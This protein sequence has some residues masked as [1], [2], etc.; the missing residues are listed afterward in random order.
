MGENDERQSGARRHEM[1]RDQLARA[2]MQ[3]APEHLFALLESTGTDGSST[4]LGRAQRLDTQAATARWLVDGLY[5]R[6]VGPRVELWLVEMQSRAPRRRPERAFGVLSAAMRQLAEGGWP[7]NDG[8]RIFL[9]EVR[10]EQAATSRRRATETLESDEALMEACAPTP[11]LDFLPS[12][13]LLLEGYWTDVLLPDPSAWPLWAFGRHAGA[14]AILAAMTAVDPETRYGGWITTLLRWIGRVRFPRDERFREAPEK[15]GEHMSQALAELVED[16]R[17]TPTESEERVRQYLAGLEEQRERWRKEGRELGRKEGREQGR[18]E[19]HEQG[20]E[21]GKR[22]A[23]L[24]LV[25][26]VS[27]E[28]VASLREIRDLEMLQDAA[29]GIIVGLKGGE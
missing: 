6:R 16:G 28:S 13:R 25:A 8:P 14:E 3:L 15:E 5:L 11:A 24:A 2:A 1:S 12:N 27:P 29:T 17:M 4:M 20:R 9:V 18:K 23:L 26:S 7:Q 19:G 10:T 22:E 21:Q